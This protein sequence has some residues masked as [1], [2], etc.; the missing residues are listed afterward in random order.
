MIGRLIQRQ[1]KAS[2]R[3]V[4]DEKSIHKN[5]TPNKSNKRHYLL[6]SPKVYAG[7]DAISSMGTA[8]LIRKGTF[9]MLLIPK[10]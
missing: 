4:I 6:K 10:A 7:T 9:P 2:I 5:V 3:A 8:R 1:R